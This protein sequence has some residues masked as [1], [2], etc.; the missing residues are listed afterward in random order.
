MDLGNEINFPIIELPPNLTQND[1]TSAVMEIL[2]T[3]DLQNKKRNVEAFVNLSMMIAT[4][5]NTAEIVNIISNYL[6]NPILLENNQFEYLASTEPDN[7]EIADLIQ[8]RCNKAFV[9]KMQEKGF[10]KEVFCDFIEYNGKKL[11]TAS[12]SNRVPRY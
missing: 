10:L 1:T 8:K 2:L 11:Y 3:T 5:S 7:Q 4:A 6:G 12:L 9:N